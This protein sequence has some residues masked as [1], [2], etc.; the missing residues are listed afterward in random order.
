MADSL[1]EFG[2]VCV[3]QYRVRRVGLVRAGY[4]LRASDCRHVAQLRAAFGC[5]EV[6]VA[7][8]F[9]EVRAFGEGAAAAVPDALDL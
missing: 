6:V 3:C 1:E 7:V 8:F 5:E 9:V 4:V 2:G